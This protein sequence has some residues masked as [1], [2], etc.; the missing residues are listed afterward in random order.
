M[1][2]VVITLRQVSEGLAFFNGNEATTTV[3]LKRERGCV[4]SHREG[5]WGIGRMH[6]LGRGGVLGE[7]IRLGRIYLLRGRG[8]RVQGRVRVLS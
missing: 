7:G 2:F 3:A 8:S 1:C 6:G 4:A 5:W